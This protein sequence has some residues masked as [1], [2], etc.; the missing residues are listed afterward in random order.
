MLA[1]ASVFLCHRSCGCTKKPTAGIQKEFLVILSGHRSTTGW[2][3]TSKVLSHECA[4][5]IC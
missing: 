2:K 4:F 5:V 1:Y 3:D